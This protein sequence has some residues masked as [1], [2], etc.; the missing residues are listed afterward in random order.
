VSA[1]AVLARAREAG[2][3]VIVAG[4]GIRVRSSAPIAEDLV[5]ELRLHRDEIRALLEADAPQLHCLRCGSSPHSLEIGGFGAKG[6]TCERC[7]AA[8]GMLP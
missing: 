2:L 8:A 5:G 3:E 4:T 7:L 6:W 1:A